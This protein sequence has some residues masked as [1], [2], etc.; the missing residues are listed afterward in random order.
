MNPGLFLDRD[1]VIVKANVRNGLPYPPS[2]L[3]EVEIL[4][5][6]LEALALANHLRFTVIVIS[7]QPDISR[8]IT[9]VTFV[10]EVNELI[11]RQTGIKHFYVCPHDDSDDCNCRKPKPGLILKASRDLG[12]DLNNSYLVGDRWRDIAAGMSA[13]CGCFFVDYGYD[14]PRPKGEYR[15]VGS[16]LQAT[17][18]IRKK[19]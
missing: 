10:E 8:G 15:V 7:N 19:S 2:N 14:E 9:T 18:E 17:L 6:T 11:S 12:I 16:L 4:D 13:G 3:L 1:G 5:G